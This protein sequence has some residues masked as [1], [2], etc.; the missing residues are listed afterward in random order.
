M[1]EEEEKEEKQKLCNPGSADWERKSVRDDQTKEKQKKTD[2][3]RV[4]L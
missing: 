3:R 1:E 4:Q 2:N